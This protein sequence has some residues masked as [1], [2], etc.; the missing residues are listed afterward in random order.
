LEKP[1]PNDIETIIGLSPGGIIFDCIRSDIGALRMSV[2]IPQASNSQSFTAELFKVLS[3][4]EINF[5]GGSVGV[6]K[7]ED[8]NKNYSKKSSFFLG[9]NFYAGR[10]FIRCAS[11][12]TEPFMVLDHSISLRVI[13]STIPGNDILQIVGF[14]KTIKVDA[15]NML[16]GLNMPQSD[17]F[18]FTNNYN[19]VDSILFAKES[20][21]LP[22]S[23][24]LS[25]ISKIAT[26]K[27]QSKAL[28]ALDIN[29][30]WDPKTRRPKDSVD[31]TQSP[32]EEILS[33]IFVLTTE[34]NK[35]NNRLA[36]LEA[37]QTNMKNILSA[38]IK[39]SRENVEEV[40]SRK[41]QRTDSP[42]QDQEDG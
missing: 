7:S 20:L 31:L 27:N 25:V 13:W 6:G 3:I 33:H 1:D 14:N 8:K 5:I 19:K 42:L 37:A 38:L 39:R 21:S 32:V 15:L 23:E 24:A 40:H 28:R 10:D 4:A 30:S 16:K 11:Q 17:F 36:C 34:M 12:C 18:V 41:R 26:T 22:L 2:D 35:V 9:I 29:E